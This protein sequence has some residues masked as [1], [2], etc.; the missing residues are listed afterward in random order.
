MTV[1]YWRICLALWLTPVHNVGKEI[2]V[3]KPVLC[4]HLF[5][6]HRQGSVQDTPLLQRESRPASMLRTKLYTYI[7][8][9]WMSPELAGKDIENLFPDPTALCERGE[10]EVV[11]V[12]FPQTWRLDF[13]WFIYYL[14]NI[15]L[16]YRFQ[17]NKRSRC[18]GRL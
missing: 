4:V 13:N 5:I 10:G 15:H 16:S 17:H 2:V 14:L 18:I 12:N 6:V 1:T 9:D 8:L 3:P 11:R 7:L